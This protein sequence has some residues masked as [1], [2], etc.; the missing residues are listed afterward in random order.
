MQA[1]LSGKKTHI[2]AGA[3]ALSTFAVSM[4]WLS[5]DQY[6]ALMGFLNAMGLSTLRLGV[7]KA[8]GQ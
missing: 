4:G 3:M 2:A 8:G 1:F 7:S 5:Q 6:L